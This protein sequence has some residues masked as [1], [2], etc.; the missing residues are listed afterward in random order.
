MWV[1]ASL[2]ISACSSMLLKSA[3]TLIV[4]IRNA[5]KGIENP[6]NLEIAANFQK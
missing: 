2:P 4:V 1:T 3:W 5:L 6:A